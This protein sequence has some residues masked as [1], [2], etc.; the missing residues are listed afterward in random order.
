MDA[1]VLPR[2]GAHVYIAPTAYVG[3]DVVLGDHVTVMHH[4]MIRG[5]IA[6][7]RIGRRT[8]LQD[9]A[10]VHTPTGVPLDID[11]EVG[12]GHRAIIHGRRVGSRTLI[13]M[14]AILLDDSEIGS[15]CIV[16]AGCVVPPGMKVPD[17]SVVMGVP[18]KIVR[19]ITEADL[20]TI[21]HVVASYIELGRKHHSGMF[22]NIA[23][24]P[25]NTLS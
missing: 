14:G 25:P 9:G 5:D 10:I 4:V 23:S 24:L 8:N 13:G 15:R 7:I 18:G 12:V 21:D 1:P 3:G 17:E 20:K 22:P 11:D 6:P 16:A 19:R 2:V